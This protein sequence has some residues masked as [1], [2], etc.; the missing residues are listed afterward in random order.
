MCLLPFNFSIDFL[1]KSC[2]QFFF[3]V[4]H[5]SPPNSLPLVIRDFWS[6]CVWFG[7]FVY[8]YL[9]GFPVNYLH[10]HWTQS[11]FKLSIYNGNNATACP[12]FSPPKRYKSHQKFSV[13]KMLKMPLKG[14]CQCLV[15][16]TI[17][18]AKSQGETSTLADLIKGIFPW[19]RGWTLA[20]SFSWNYTPSYLHKFCNLASTIVRKYITSWSKIWH[21]LQ[22]CLTNIFSTYFIFKF[23][24]LLQFSRKTV[25]DKSLG[26]RNVH[27]GNSQ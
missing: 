4:F 6:Y 21:Y 7:P 13:I 25:Y 9:R 15:V 3:L 18:W 27:H 19:G 17:A 22:H 1:W 16:T 20:Q 12:T 5:K 10:F 24:S 14:N 26:V 2:L 23:F 8:N 11:P